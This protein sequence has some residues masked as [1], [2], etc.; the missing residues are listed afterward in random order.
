MKKLFGIL[1]LVI[2]M[3]LTT[4]V[5]FAKD[6]VKVKQTVKININSASVEQLCSIKGI[7]TKKAQSI[8]DFRKTNGKFKKVED[9]MLVKGIGEK[10]FAKIKN[11]I[12]I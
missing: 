11:K 6:N 4:P 8:V 3:A 2:V 5:T 10:M 7:G 9:I 1:G 12:T